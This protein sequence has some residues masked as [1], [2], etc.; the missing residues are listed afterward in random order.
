MCCVDS[1]IVFLPV[2][3]VDEI[4]Y[5]AWS[6]PRGKKY[7]AQ[8]ISVRE[9]KRYDLYFMDGDVR[10]EVPENEMR[11][12]SKK[13]RTDK[14]LGKKFFDGG[15]KPTKHQKK[16]ERGEFTVLVGK[17]VG[18]SRCTEPSYWCERDTFGSNIQEKRDIQLFAVSYITKLIEEYDNE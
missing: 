7:L 11:K 6:N 17:G 8:I 2:G 14:L 13:Q 12:L 1:V 16:F 3:Q 9:N 5:A 15:D 18:D 4:V 10:N